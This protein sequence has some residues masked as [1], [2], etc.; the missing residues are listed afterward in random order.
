[1]WT[2]Y[3]SKLKRALY[4]TLKDYLSLEIAGKKVAI[5]YFIEKRGKKNFFVPF[6]GKGKP[7][8]LKN[9]VIF[10]ALKEGVDLALLSQ[11]ELEEFL[12]KHRIGIDC[13]GFV[14]NLLDT[15]LKK[16]GHPGIDGFLRGIKKGGRRMKWGFGVRGVDSRSFLSEENSFFVPLKEAKP[17][18]II[19]LSHKRSTYNHLMLVLEKKKD[20]LIYTHVSSAIGE[21]PVVRV[22]KAKVEKDKI[23]WEERLKNGK[24][25]EASYRFKGIIRLKCTTPE[26][27]EKIKPWL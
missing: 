19:F 24:E 15:S 18:D 4:Q 20:T 17:G 14:Y 25:I 26:F 22:A 2:D 9:T 6:S 10:F 8:S 1:M 7:E 3:Y 23:L 16:I 11:K 21:K 13:S 27:L 12:V 5:P